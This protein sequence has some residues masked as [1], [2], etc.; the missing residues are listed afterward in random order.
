VLLEKREDASIIGGIVTQ[1]GD[2]VFD[3]SVRTQLAE[4]RE[5]LLTE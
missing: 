1:L 4:M 2:L 5:E 3:G